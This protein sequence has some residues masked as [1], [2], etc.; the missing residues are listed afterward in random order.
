MRE[1]DLSYI[2]GIFDGEGSIHITKLN[3][4][5]SYKS[6]KYVLHFYVGNTNLEMLKELKSFFGGSLTLDARKDVPNSKPFWHWNL[7]PKAAYLVIKELLPYLKIKK[8]RAEVAIKFY[9]LCKSQ[10]RNIIRGE[11]GTA[12]GTLKL[13]NNEIKEREK[14]YQQMKLLNHRGI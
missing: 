8:E 12:L 7:G 13:N 11:K 5:Q 3:P 1:L 9:E 4:T 6:T 10:K 14:I 2:A